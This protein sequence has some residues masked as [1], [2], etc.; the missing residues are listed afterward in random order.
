MFQIQ[1]YSNTKQTTPQSDGVFFGQ[2]Y[3]S[4]DLSVCRFCKSKNL[5]W[6][7]FL[8][9][10]PIAGWTY[11]YRAR[12]LDCKQSYGVEHHPYPEKITKDYEWK[13]SKTTLRSIK[14]LIDQ[15]RL[16]Q[17]NLPFQVNL[18]ALLKNEPFQTRTKPDRQQE[19]LRLW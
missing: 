16:P 11:H 2:E 12:C 5:S 4:T 10:G 8:N 14:R 19:A 7:K 18:K 13:L 3:Y 9:C 17:F 1:L 15:N 6:N